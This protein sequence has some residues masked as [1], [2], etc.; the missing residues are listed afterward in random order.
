MTTPRTVFIRQTS[1][2]NGELSPKLKARSELTQYKRGTKKLRNMYTLAHGGAQRR[3]GTIYVGE[4]KDSTKI[5][6][7]IPYVFSKTLAYMFV[8]NDGKFQFIRSSAFLEASPG[9]RVELTHTFT[10]AELFDITYA[11][12][13][14]QLYMFHP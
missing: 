9:V 3:P 13:G 1:F 10:D 14:S 6:R 12:I 5:A 4:V 8:L 7:L 11:Q 2:A